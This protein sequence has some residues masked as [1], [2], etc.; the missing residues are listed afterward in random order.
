V[1]LPLASVAYNP[2]VVHDGRATGNRVQIAPA[3]GQTL[4]AT[5][6]AAVKFDFTPQ[7]I[8][9][10]NWSGYTEIILQGTN[11]N[12]TTPPLNF[13]QNP[14]FELNVTPVNTTEFAVTAWTKYNNTTDSSIGC[15]HAGGEYTVNNP[16]APTAD[17]NQYLYVNML[18]PAVTGGVYQD[19][20]PLK[21]NTTYTLTVAIGSRNDRINSPGIISLING[22]DYTGTVLAT[23]NGL[24]ATTNTWADYTVTFTTGSSVSGDLTIALSALGDATLIQADFDNVRLTATAPSATPPTLGAATVSGGNLILTG[25]GGT[26]GAGYT[27]LT[28]T[29]LS[30]PVVWTTNST[31]TLNGSGAFTNTIPIGANPASFF[32][33]RLP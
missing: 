19:V 12:G 31:G 33:L 32:R 4:L 3:I 23:T 15:G 30:A 9:D 24:P 13:V 25:T 16:L 14:S 5:N 17:G 10:F 6:V 18:N 2:F 8:Q 1:F 27:W 11:S 7:G 28:T 20:G 29:N 21:T 26:P 22:T